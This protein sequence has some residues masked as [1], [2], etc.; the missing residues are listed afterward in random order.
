MKIRIPLSDATEAKITFTPP[1]GSTH[2]ITKVLAPE[3]Y[4]ALMAAL[5]AQRP[6]ITGQS[7]DDVKTETDEG[8]TEPDYAALIDVIKQTGGSVEINGVK[9]TPCNEYGRTA[10]E[11][12]RFEQSTTLGA[13]GISIEEGA[14]T[15]SALSEG[16]A[17]ETN[18][19][20][21]T[22]LMDLPLKIGST[23]RYAGEGR[24]IADE[25]SGRGFALVEL[26]SG[27]GQRVVDK[28]ALT[29]V[30]DKAV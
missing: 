18:K 17:Q 5:G 1:S 19:S 13:H 6:N 7:W 26:T 2:Y 29:H 30:E 14:V 28:R 23:I 4:D 10:E 22:H 25:Y 27:A 16:Q 9:I 12:L 21:L 24:V 20:R 11:Q 15:V 8:V 3:E